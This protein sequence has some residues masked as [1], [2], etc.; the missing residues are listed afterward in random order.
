M[1]R[2]SIVEF[3]DINDNTFT[4]YVN[5]EPKCE[6]TLHEDGIIGITDLNGELFEN[7]QLERKYI[8]IMLEN[9]LVDADGEMYKV[10][11]KFIK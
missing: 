5:N 10:K 4:M 2:N 7:E 8:T 9:T 11:A 6:F 3:E 1:K